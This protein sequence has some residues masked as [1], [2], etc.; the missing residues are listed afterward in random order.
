[1]S[2]IKIEENAFY[3]LIDRVIEQLA[4]KNN[5]SVERWIDGKEAMR[6]LGISS[7]TTLQKLRDDG[8]ITYSQPSKKII[9]YDVCSIDAYIERHIQKF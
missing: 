6:K 4:H 2:I 7:P 9:L 3:E 1:M 8:H 5:T